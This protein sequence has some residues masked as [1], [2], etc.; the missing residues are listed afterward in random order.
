MGK[1]GQYILHK[2]TKTLPNCNI[3]NCLAFYD[4][5]HSSSKGSHLGSTDGSLFAKSWK[6]F[7][8]WLRP[9]CGESAPVEITVLPRWREMDCWV[10]RF[11]KGKWSCLPSTRHQSPTMTST[12]YF[13]LHTNVKEHQISK[14]CSKW[15]STFYPQRWY[16][17]H[18]SQGFH[19]KC[20]LACAPHF[21]VPRGHPIDDNAAQTCWELIA[22]QRKKRDHLAK[23]SSNP[24][25]LVT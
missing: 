20:P 4:C 11:W 9:H 10:E 8:N 15:F 18:V 6:R 13:K 16:A 1:T 12:K 5:F 22:R 3:S 25:I 17:R 14:C 2:H 21:A 24:G 19:R 23:A 7:I